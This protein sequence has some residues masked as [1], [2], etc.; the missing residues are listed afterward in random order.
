MNKSSSLRLGVIVTAL[1]GALFAM[2]ASAHGY[3]DHDSQAH[4]HGHHQY[5]HPRNVVVVVRPQHRPAH[6]NHGHH[7]R[8]HHPVARIA[9][10]AGLHALLH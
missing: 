7:H 5:G 2:P 10:L 9:A 4:H 8:G 1:C 3:H 6:H